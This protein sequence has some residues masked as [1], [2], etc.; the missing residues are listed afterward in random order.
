M[1]LANK[2]MEG[3]ARLDYIDLLKLIGIMMV[4]T[5]HVPLLAFDFMSKVTVGKMIQYAF[6]LVAEGVPLFMMVNGFLLLKKKECDLRKHV[7]KMLSILRVFLIWAVILIVVGALTQSPVEKL[8]LS[9]VVNYVLA[10]NVGSKYTGVL[11]F[12]QNLL[13]V[14]LIFP[15]LFKAYSEDFKLFRYFFYIVVFY[16]VGLD[17]LEL[18][19]DYIAANQVD[20]SLLNNIMF[21]ASR[22]NVLGDPWYLYYFMLGGMIWHYKDFIIEKRILFIVLGALSWGLAWTYGLIM[23][24]SIGSVY[25]E[26]FNYGS[27]FM[28]MFLIGLFALTCN[29]KKKGFI[30]NLI[31][32]MGRNTMGIYLTHYIFIFVIYRFFMLDTH[33]PLVRLVL[34]TV[35]LFGSHLLSLGLKKIPKL[36]GILFF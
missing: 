34:F 23:S 9:S 16:A 7:K 5:L 19:R 25:N 1:D 10:T 28:T 29:Y 4:L 30:G 33:L 11:W 2:E 8:T 18:L 32:S 13:G 36:S 14:Y 12:L 26:A 35:V 17:T 27:I 24:F 20:P 3:K 6:R 22:F 15:I 21:F 31:S